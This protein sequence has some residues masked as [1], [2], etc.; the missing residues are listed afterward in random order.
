[1]DTEAVERA[2]GK[3]DAEAPPTYGGSDRGSGRRV[4][5][6]DRAGAPCA[7]TGSTLEPLASSCESTS[8]LSSQLGDASPAEG[9]GMPTAAG[10]GSSSVKLLLVVQAGVRGRD[11][12]VGSRD[13]GGWRRAAPP[14]AASARTASGDGVTSTSRLVLAATA[15][16]AALVPELRGFKVVSERRW[17]VGL[18]VS[19]RRISPAISR[20]SRCAYV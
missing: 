1:M 2:S 16:A 10:V 15:M 9:V 18:E 14:A 12:D 3:A 19:L 7:A 17:A 5:G 4:G 8:S 6:G 20:R 13:G 11:G